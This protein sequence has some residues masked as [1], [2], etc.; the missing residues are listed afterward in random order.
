[1]RK[2]GLAN[3]QDVALTGQLM[4]FILLVF[5]CNLVFGDVSSATLD[6]IIVLN[7]LFEIE[8]FHVNALAYLVLGAEVVSPVD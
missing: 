1:V 8:S 7:I 2:A 3:S 6:L 5:F 4:E